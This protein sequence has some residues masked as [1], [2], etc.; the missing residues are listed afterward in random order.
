MRKLTLVSLLFLAVILAACGGNG[1]ASPTGA[2]G[3]GTGDAAAGQALFNQATIGSSA[4]CMTCHSLD[5]GVTLV[6]PSL[7]HVGTDAA[8]MESGKSAE[9]YI[10]ESITQPD[11]FVVEGFPPGVMPK[12]YD[13]DLSDQQLNDLVAFLLSKQ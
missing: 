11:A 10:R 1:A 4:G 3:G 12:T 13:Q 6:G 9:Q 7:A 5:E 8:T 2:T